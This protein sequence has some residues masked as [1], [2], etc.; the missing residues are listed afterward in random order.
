MKRNGSGPSELKIH[1]PLAQKKEPSDLLL[2]SIEPFVSWTRP[3]DDLKRERVD[4]VTITS[5][6]ASA[7]MLK[8]NV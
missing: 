4:Q 1:T 5:V 7:L 3:S 2:L 8:D 6:A